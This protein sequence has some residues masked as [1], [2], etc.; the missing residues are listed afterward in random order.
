MKISKEC[1]DEALTALKDF[2]KEELKQYAFDVFD[3]AKK[4]TNMSNMRAFEEAMKEI[5]DERLKS[6]FESAMTAANNA[7]KIEAAADRIR[8]GKA[9]LQN[10]LVKRHVNQADNVAAAQ[11]A[12][13]EEIEGV[14]FKK[15]SREEVAYLSTGKND[16]EIADAYDGKKVE[17]PEA[18]KIAKLWKDV[19]FPERNAG[20]ISS[21]AMPFDHINE[22]RSF[23][24]SHDSNKLILGG[25]SAI[26][27]ARSKEKFTTDFAKQK[28]IDTIKK[29]FDLIHSDAVLPDGSVDEARL[30]QIIGKMYDDITTGKSDINTR[31]LVVNDRVAIQNRSRR[32][33]QP[34]SMRDFV[35]YNQEYGQ[36][37]LM[38]AMLTDM[39][40]SGNKIGIARILGDSPHAA[41]LDL[42]KVEQEVNPHTGKFGGLWWYQSDLYFQQ[43]TGVNKTAVSPTLAAIDANTRAVTAMARLPLVALRSLPDINYM[44]TF[45]MNHGYNYFEA[46]GA[47]L[48][49]MFDLIPSKQRKYL[50][51]QYASMFRQHLGYV[52]R[53][54]EM[55][56]ISDRLNKISTGF[57]KVN[58][59]HAFDNGNKMSGLELVAKGLGRHSSRKFENLPLATR[60]WINK[61]MSPEEWELLRH[62]TQKKLFTVDNVDALS[63]K[64]IKEFYEAGDKLRPLHE[65]RNDLYRRVHAMSQIATENMVLNPGAFERA[66][67]LM[68][69]KP[70]TISGVILRQLSHFKSYTLSFID[71]VLVQGYRSA[72]ANQQK[73]A[74]ATAQLVGSM[75]LAYGVMYF[76]N[77]AMGKSMPDIRKM[78]LAEAEKFMIELI[79]PG[80]AMFTGV[81]DPKHQNSDM[82]MSLLASP[83]LRLIGN[84]LATFASAAF[85]TQKDY[86]KK[87]GKHFVDTMAY[88]APIKTTPILSPLLNQ[89]MGEKGHLEPGQKHYYGR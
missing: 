81:L 62:K 48:T 25:R 70:G 5:N 46:W 60:N 80:L 28:W 79:Q 14:F 38:N 55:N 41:Y 44:A 77:L 24:N 20:L 52:A 31:S 22:D 29:R 7:R 9:N 15:V 45:A 18:N 6:Y 3:K 4:Y 34:K 88:V 82:I 23:R 56:N 42:R 53:Y 21:N 89:V 51:K 84:A 39:Q 10:T 35:E 65:V 16:L 68:G 66:T 64:E 43:V 50:A 54:G 86:A 1:M 17:S 47:H 37:N 36:G 87:V 85:V 73:L 2:S 32:R 74:W 69:T 27:E 49:N 30:N 75:P 58:L 76:E 40:S 59:L 19:Y 72:D 83:S 63:E 8:K 13:Q 78:N 33:L 71:K 57:F 11:A 26:N 61:F 67:L 12:A